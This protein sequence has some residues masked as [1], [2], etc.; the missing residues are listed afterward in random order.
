VGI[1]VKYRISGEQERAILVADRM[2]SWGAIGVEYNVSKLEKVRDDSLKIAGVA[3]R[4]EALIEE[5][6]DKLRAKCENAKCFDDVKQIVS[7]CVSGIIVDKITDAV[8]KPMGMDAARFLDLTERNPTHQFVGEAMTIRQ[9]LSNSLHVVLAVREGDSL[10]LILQ[11]PTFSYTPYSSPEISELSK[12]GF[13]T[14][15]TGSDSAWW[16]LVHM[17]YDPADDI[18]INLTKAL[19]A[20]IQAEESHGVGKNTDIMI[21]DNKGIRGIPNQQSLVDTARRVYDKL[22]KSQKEIIRKAYQ[23]VSI[24]D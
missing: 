2:I 11:Q 5:F 21:L 3:A 10:K 22:I 16:T 6:F 18:K 7:D 15:G 8:L 12:L 14:V 13:A 1:I 23:Q 24:S 17:G 4:S 9:N 20:K 19:L